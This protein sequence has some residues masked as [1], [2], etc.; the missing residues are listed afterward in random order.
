VEPGEDLPLKVEPFEKVVTLRD[1]RKV[2][3]R[4]ISVQLRGNWAPVNDVVVDK[5]GHLDL[6]GRSYCR[7]SSSVVALPATK[8][9]ETLKSAGIRV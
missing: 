3:A 8:G 4:T 1:S 5:V 9:K 7:D 6:A 2:R